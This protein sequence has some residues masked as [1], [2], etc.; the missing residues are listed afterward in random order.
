MTALGKTLQVPVAE[1]AHY[2]KNFIRLAVCELRFPTLL[3][4]ETRAPIQFQKA[5]RQGFPIYERATDVNMNV[6]GVARAAVHRFRSKAGGAWTVSMRQS[7]LTLETTH[8]ESFDTFLRRLAFIAEAA[9][10]TIESNFLTRVGLRYVNSLQVEQQDL[11]GWVNPTLVQPLVDGTFG[12]V[13]NYLQQVVGATE[14]GGYVFR[15]GTDVD[16]TG[17]SAYTLDVDFFAENAETTE[18]SELVT[19]LHARAYSLFAWAIGPKALQ[20]LQGEGKT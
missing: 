3:E 7:A 12:A 9:A 10:S 6:G 18:V 11:E 5:I 1:P 17:R 15:H 14:V 8:Y 13:T 4:L 20:F 16:D 2:R 19:D